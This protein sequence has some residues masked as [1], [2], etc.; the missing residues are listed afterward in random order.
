MMRQ[1]IP[2]PVLEMQKNLLELKCKHQISKKDICLPQLVL[3]I[4]LVSQLQS[5]LM[6]K[7]KTKLNKKFSLNK[8]NKSLHKNKKARRKLLL[9]KKISQE[10]SQ[11]AMKMTWMNHLL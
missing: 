10:N 7:L 4:H 2:L 9:N 11:D 3:K 8:N 6:D 5:W 1:Q